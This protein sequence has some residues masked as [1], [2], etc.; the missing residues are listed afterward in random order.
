MEINPYSPPLADCP[1][2]RVVD[3]DQVL[4]EMRGVARMYFGMG[5]IGIAAVAFLGLVPIWLH[6][7]FPPR[8]RP[9]AEQRMRTAVLVLLTIP[10]IG[11][12]HV[13]HRLRTRPQGNLPY[14]RSI[15][16]IL[17]TGFFPYLTWPGMICFRRATRHFPRYCELIAADQRPPQP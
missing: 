8:P 9:P 1:I 3:D 4:R 6:D 13:S 14:A 17:A 12:V 5:V 2:A 15:A 16:L 7:D 11:A 10:F